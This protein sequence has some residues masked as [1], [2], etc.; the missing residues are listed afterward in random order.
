VIRQL[1]IIGEAANKI[2]KDLKINTP[3]I[4]WRPISDARNTL[5]HGYFT[6]DLDIV[7]GMIEKDIPKLKD[8]I[9]GLIQD[10]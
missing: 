2:S 3:E 6:V 9:H 8:Q 5:I 10:L 7:W 4:P 1:E